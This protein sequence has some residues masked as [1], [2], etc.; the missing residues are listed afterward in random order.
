[1]GNFDVTAIGEAL[2]DFT[3]MGATGNGTPLYAANAGGG[4]ANLAVAVARLGG[5]VAFIGQVGDDLF[6]RRLERILN[7]EGIH[8][9]GLLLSGDYHTSLAFVQLDENG[10]R[11]FCFFRN[12]GADEMLETTEVRY[13]LIAKSRCLH[14]SSVVFTQETAR[15]ATLA[16]AAYA[17]SHGVLVSYDPNWRPMLWK[18]PQEGLAALRLGVPLADILKATPEELILLTGEAD[19]SAAVGSLMKS[20]VRVVLL[21]R[22][23]DGS[24]VFTRAGQVSAPVVPVQVLDT[25]GAGDACLGSFLYKLIQAMK[26]GGMTAASLDHLP[27][28]ELGAMALYANAAASLK[29]SR[30]GGIPAMPTGEELDVFL[31]D[32]A[33]DIA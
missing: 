2:I 25:T 26:R 16:A 4:P 8:T 28:G 1:M 31:G 30:Y 6:G 33:I 14:F 15:S 24:T 17:R 20:G 9:D 7:Q 27:L 21:T 12:P 32:H 19:E 18:D 10:D 11:D 29:V 22:G 13:D 5:A 23:V 3:P